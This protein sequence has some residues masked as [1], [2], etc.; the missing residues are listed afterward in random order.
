[1]FYYTENQK[2]I[3][4]YIFVL[5]QKW[6]VFF[7]YPLNVFLC[8]AESGSIFVSHSEMTYTKTNS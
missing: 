2:L 4:K 6:L 7:N 1:M 3:K 5:P 8:L